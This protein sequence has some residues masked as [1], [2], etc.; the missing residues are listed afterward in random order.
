MHFVYLLRSVVDG[1]FYIGRTEDLERRL[2][3]HNSG[4]GYYTRRKRP[5]GLIYYEAYKELEEA[6]EREKQIKRFGSAYSALL[7]RLKLK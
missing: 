5:Y 4:E 1:S 7:K 3:E 2:K 6:K